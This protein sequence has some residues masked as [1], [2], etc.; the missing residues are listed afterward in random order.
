MLRSGQVLGTRYLGREYGVVDTDGRQPPISEKQQP[1]LERIRSGAERNH[2]EVLTV[3]GRKTH[4]GIEYLAIAEATSEHPRNDSA[5]IV[6]LENAELFAVWIEM[7]AS[8]WGGHDQA[9]SSIAS[10][11]SG[12]GGETWGEHRVEVSPGEGD[13]SVYNPSLVVLPDG[14]LLFFYLKYHHLVWNE[15]LEA[16]GYVKRSVDG[17]RT[18]SEP[19]AIWDHQPYGCANHTF[20][21]LAD[22]RLLKSCERVPVWGTYPKCV[23]SSG[24]FISD[25]LGKT[26]REPA[27][28]VSLP[29]RGTMENH[30]AETRSGT[31]VMVVRS[32]LGCAFLSR[33][34]DRGESWSHPQATG[35]SAT[36]SMPSLTRIPAT[37][38]LLLVWNNAPYDHTCGHSGKRTPLT[39]AVSE[40]EGRSWGFI[41]HIEDDPLFEFSNVACTHLAEKKL[42]ISYFTSRME[43]PEPP[44]RFGRER[45]S[46]KGAITTLDWVYS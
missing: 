46:L 24:C 4:P 14:E 16:S 32:Q 15:A 18:W 13:R 41:K 5:S 1:W 17:G 25:D 6:E 35:L 10:M 2:K 39:V 27:Q 36:E 45:M 3:D 26:W 31:L 38:D 21:L 7:H 34:T 20:T 30:I 40:D 42:I 28:L 23:S 12:D 33:S 37:G 44:G 8:E 19:V 43:N 29:L 11:R 9:P 22:G